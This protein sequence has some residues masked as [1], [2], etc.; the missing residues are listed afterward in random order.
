MV[1]PNVREQR[2]AV[3]S[4]LSHMS[5]PNGGPV[6][7]VPLLARL[8]TGSAAAK[9]AGARLRAY[10]AEDGFDREV[11]AGQLTDALMSSVEAP[12]LDPKRPTLNPGDMKAQAGLQGYR[13]GSMAVDARA[14]EKLTGIVVTP[15]EAQ[16]LDARVK[17]VAQKMGL[18]HEVGFLTERAH[19][20][21]TQ[22]KAFIGTI[23]TSRP[24]QP[25][26]VGLGVK[27]ETLADLELLSREFEKDVP[28][29]LLPM[30][31]D[32]LKLEEDQRIQAILVHEHLEQKAIHDGSAS[33]H[34]AAIDGAPDTSLKVDPRVREH[35]QL[36]RRLDRSL[37]GPLP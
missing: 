22:P 30:F 36:F 25:L 37:F 16:R 18:D 10:F 5:G 7:L 20:P 26:R 3:S 24:G 2:Q 31:E 28:A 15:A 14:F 33:P 21:G 23:E 8:D 9:H 12:E 32:L 13:D 11:R 29:G 19:T 6:A 27:A 34:R 1:K 17:S 35:L 4:H